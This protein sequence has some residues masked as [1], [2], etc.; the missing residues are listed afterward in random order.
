VCNGDSGSGMI[1]QLN[2]KYY[3]RGIVSVSIALQNHLKCDPQ[4]Y[5]V[6]T[7]VSKFLPWIERYL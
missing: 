4:H 3:L 5:V 1:F 7:D 6:F 2:N